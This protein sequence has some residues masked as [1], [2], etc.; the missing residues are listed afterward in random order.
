MRVIGQGSQTTKQEDQLPPPIDPGALGNILGAGLHA[1]V[2]MSADVTNQVMDTT[3]A[4]NIETLEDVMPNDQASVA[5]RGFRKRWA[6]K[7]S[8][9]SD[10]SDCTDVLSGVDLDRDIASPA[11]PSLFA[12]VDD[13]DHPPQFDNGVVGS[14]SSSAV[15]ADHSFLSNAKWSQIQLPWESKMMQPIFD[16]DPLPKV[17]LRHDVSWKAAMGVHLETGEPEADKT[18]EPSGSLQPVFVKCVHSIREQT[19][20]EMRE[21]DMHAAIIKWHL[22]VRSNSSAS[23]VGI[24]IERDPIHGLEIIR[25]SMGVKSP[26]TVLSRANAM[27]AFMR[28]HCIEFPSEP[29]L[30]LREEHAWRYVSFLSESHAPPSRATSFIQACRFSHHILGF[31]GA[32]EVVNSRRIT[33]LSEIQLAD[34][35]PAKQARPLTVYEM[36]QLHKISG[37][38]ARHVKDRV[39]ASHL[40]L[41][42]Y[43]R[44]RHSDTLQIEDVLHDHSRSHGYIQLRTRFHKGSKT[45]AKKS[46]LLPIVASSSGVGYPEWIQLWWENRMEAGLPV[47]GELK[48]PLMP[49][50]F[51]SG[52][53]WS[54]RALTSS[55]V[56]GILKAFLDGSS[57]VLLT[58][59]SMKTTLLSWCS[60]ASVDKEHRRLLGRHSTAVVDADSIYARDIMYSP[61]DSLDKVIAAICEGRFMPDAPR[62]Q[63]WPLAEPISRTP[64]PVA[65]PQ[66]SALPMTPPFVPQHV[67]LRNFGGGDVKAEQPSRVEN[68]EQSFDGVTEVVE[69]SSDSDCD[70]SSTENAASSSSEDFLR[71]VEERPF[72]SRAVGPSFPDASEQWF[73]HSQTK[74]IH[75]TEDVNADTKVSKCGRRLGSRF[76][77]VPQVVD[78]T[79]KCRIC[80]LGR[81]QV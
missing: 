12:P 34:K 73:Q 22:V 39:L 56:T 3:G 81:R 31:R 77:N 54:R 30:P 27:L 52:E 23:D 45:A 72:K 19:F 11:T 65:G 66:T 67:T 2:E 16:A 53:G 25:A 64:I 80:F 78:W 61:L 76:R 17:D 46:L 43:C 48:G 58:S 18:P 40:L 55:E 28:W 15:M 63:Y 71:P 69:V 13:F 70:S 4:I 5:C 60:K 33:G 21:R 74:T 50:P 35:Q 29:L 32:I 10:K 20:I 49:A 38:P 47:Q 8:E 44:C 26:N 62:S 37:D 51:A 7:R 14:A 24:Q 6:N 57:D 75:A 1:G 79:A 59:H 42:A 36:Q 9:G 41:M 68:S